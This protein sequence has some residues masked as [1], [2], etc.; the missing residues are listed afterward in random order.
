MQPS[1]AKS[2]RNQ[3]INQS[4]NRGYPPRTHGRV[5][6]GQNPWAGKETENPTQTRAWRGLGGLRTRSRALPYAAASPETTTEIIF[7]LIT[8]QMGEQT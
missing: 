6:E 1:A 7:N 8:E 5:H 2:L 3:S 4:T